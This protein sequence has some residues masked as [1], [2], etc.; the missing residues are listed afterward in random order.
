MGGPDRKTWVVVNLARTFNSAD[1]ALAFVE[2]LRNFPTVIK[3]DGL[4][5]GKG[6]IVCDNRE[7]AID[8]VNEISRDRVFGSAGDRLLIE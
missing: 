7:Q 2:N 8:A 5:A 4:A 3:A 1:E 6:V